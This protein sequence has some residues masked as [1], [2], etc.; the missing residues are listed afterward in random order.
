MKVGFVG[1]GHMG[2]GMAASLLKAG[3]EVIVYNRTRAKAEPLIARG[4]RVVASVADACRE[5]VVITMLAHDDAVEGLVL[6]KGGVIDSLPKGGIHI[7]SSTISVAL[8]SEL[9]K[10]HAK[11]GQRF[12][13]APVFGRPDVAAAGQL[14]VITA[15]SADAIAAA[16]PL[17]D[18]IGQKTFVVSETPKAANLVKLSGNFLLAVVIESL[19]EA[20]ALVGKLK[21]RP[22]LTPKPSLR[23]TLLHRTDDAEAPALRSQRTIHRWLCSGARTGRIRQGDRET[24][25]PRGSPPRLFSAAARQ[26]HN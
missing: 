5:S 22:N 4:A 24:L 13:A 8:S 15:G 20:M 7:S 12:V 1:L 14:F 26:S 9:A 25:S 18:A 19:G 10:A 2:S 11:A 16:T 6:G 3:H 17:F 23:L 21:P